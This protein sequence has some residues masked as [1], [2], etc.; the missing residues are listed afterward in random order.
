LDICD[1]HRPDLIGP[2]HRQL[3]QEIRARHPEIIV[4]LAA[5]ATSIAVGGTTIIVALINQLASFGMA[6]K[7][8]EYSK[9][10]E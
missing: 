9:E 5:I 8:V 6:R 10:L 1:I 7:S 2:R 3:A 4:R